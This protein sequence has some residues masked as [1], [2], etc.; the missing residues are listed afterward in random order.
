[1][2]HIHGISNIRDIIRTLQS[3]RVCRQTNWLNVDRLMHFYLKN[4][5][6]IT[7]M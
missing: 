7:K 5:T 3:Y 4:D 1:M 2:Q 6:P